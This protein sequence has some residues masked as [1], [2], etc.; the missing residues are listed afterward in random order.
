MSRDYYEVLGVA[1][2]ASED[3]LKKAFRRLAREYHPD[4]NPG[5]KAAEEHFKEI[6]EAYSVLSD[7]EKRR[8]YDQFG[9]AEAGAGPE[10]AGFGSQDFGGFGNIND[11]FDA[12]FGGGRSQAGPQRGRDLQTEIVL[13]LED[14]FKG[15][16]R[17]VRLSRIIS[18]RRCGGSG[19]EPG[20][21]VETCP[22]CHGQGQVS[23]RRQTPFG[24][25]VTTEPCPECHG[26]G[27]RV[28]RP[29]TACRGAGRVR[30]SDTVKVRIPAGVGEGSQVRLTGQGEAG[31]E[32]GPAGDLY[33]VIHQ[34]PHPLF[35]REGADLHFDLLVSY[36]EMALGVQVEVQ[37]IDGPA[38]LEVP[39]GTQPEDVVRVRGRGMPQIRG[40]GRGDLVGHVRVE[41]PRSVSG[42][43]R[44]LLEELRRLER[45]EAK[46]SAKGFFRRVRDAL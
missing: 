19:A 30:S 15:V 32:G 39:G 25:F 14:C 13:T 7:S 41:V 27:R 38:M 1:R 17:D 22:R 40:R 18:C 44:E 31:P 37:G 8:R 29:C 10:G 11:I 2:T 26:R 5:D 35:T 16:E 33:I 12:F 20:S 36:P 46:S 28:T 34:K 42:R 6:N 9:T 3:E 43:E 45:R 24:Q 21:S 4:R 23:S